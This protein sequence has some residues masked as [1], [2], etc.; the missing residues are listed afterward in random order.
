MLETFARTLQLELLTFTEAKHGRC[1]DTV[2]AIQNGLDAIRTAVPPDSESALADLRGWREAA[3]LAWKLQDSEGYKVWSQRLLVSQLGRDGLRHVEVPGN[4]NC[5]FT[6]LSEQK[7]EVNGTL[8]DS[9]GW[10]TLICNFMRRRNRSSAKVRRQHRRTVW[11]MRVNGK[12]GDQDCIAAA[13][14][15][16]GRAIVIWSADRGL[17]NPLIQPPTGEFRLALG[18][19]KELHFLYVNQAGGRCNNH[20][21]AML[22]DTLDWTHPT[23]QARIRAT[24]AGENEEP[25]CVDLCNESEKSGESDDSGDSSDKSVWDT[26]GEAGYP[27]TI[28]GGD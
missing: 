19:V 5:W 4:G 25:D 23:S 6:S 14:N 26:L 28:T 7:V 21:E 18:P 3:E 12:W 17:S 9:A 13:V 8:P 2:K 15:I 27:I 16:T 20:Y 11:A 22:G 10:R 24:T 1:Q